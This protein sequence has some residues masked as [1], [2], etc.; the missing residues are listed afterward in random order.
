MLEIY[1]ELKN[2]KTKV[3]YNGFNSNDYTYNKDLNIENK[4]LFVGSRESYKN[5]DKAVEAVSETSNINLAIVGAPL[6][7]NEKSYLD[8]KLPNR[9]QSFTHISNND[10]N[11][12]YNQSICLL[13]LS[14]YEGFGI[15]V[16]EAMSSGCPVIALNKSSIPEVAGNAG[17]L[18]SNYD[19]KT[20]QKAIESLRDDRNLRSEH[21]ELGRINSKRFSWDK[22]FKEV[23][24]FY[25]EILE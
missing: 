19:K 24:D 10:L 21:I 12:L 4:A 15:P 18:F 11:K 17:I 22:C 7:E 5:F 3:I 25:H 20:V 13:Y 1:P 16:L 23:L 9:Y 14:E 8:R 2:K 6:T